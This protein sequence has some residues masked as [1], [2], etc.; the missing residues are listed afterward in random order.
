MAFLRSMPS[1]IKIDSKRFDEL[2]DL[3][4]EIWDLHY[5]PIIG[6]EQVDYMLNKMY[7]PSGLNQQVGEGQSF[8]FIEQSNTII[9]FLGLSLKQ[10]GFIHKFYIHPNEQ[11]RGLGK[12]VFNLIIDE[13]NHPKTIQLTVNRQN[14]KSINFYFKCGFKIKSVE[15]FDIGN[16][17]FMND[18]VMKWR[19]PQ[20]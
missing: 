10:G 11:G 16:D 15:D 5:V 13:L 19:N 1:L 8:Y 9:G 3:A 4:R 14:F 20:I 18:F 6:Q 12:A 2:F 7:S 17:Y